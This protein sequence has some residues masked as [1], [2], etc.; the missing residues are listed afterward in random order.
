MAE[1]ALKEWINPLY[2]VPETITQI[3]KTFNSHKEI[4]SIQLGQFLLASKAEKLQKALEKSKWAHAYVP[5]MYSYSITTNE[6]NFKD[7]LALL[8]T[9]GF[10]TLL[11]TMI[12]KQ[13]KTVKPHALSFGQKDYTLLHDN[14]DEKEHI[15]CTFDFTKDWPKNAGGQMVFTHP[16]AEAMIFQPSCNALNIVAVSKD[17]HMFVKYINANAAKKRM[18]VIEV[19]ME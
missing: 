5:H 8:N 14:I 15:L 13:I 11:G 2:L 16:E 3:E 6:T 19:N 1:S 9:N 4:K 18:I 7:F 10:K 17:V 12:K